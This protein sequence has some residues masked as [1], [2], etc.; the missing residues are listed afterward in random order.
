MSPLRSLHKR[1]LILGGYGTFGARIAEMLASEPGIQIIIAGRDRFKAELLANRLH[2]RFPDTPIEGLRL[3]H[4]SINLPAQ[5][6]DLNLQLLI[7]CAGPF[8]GQGYHIAAACIKNRINYIDIADAT[9]FVCGISAL[10]S[11]AE[12]AGIQVISGA[13]SLPAL[14]S[15]ALGTLTR[16]FSQV[17]DIDITIAPAHRISRGLATVRSG[18]ESL[19]REF[20][21]TRNGTRETTYTGDDFRAIN[22]AHPVG[23]R[24]VCNFDV[25]DLQLI[26]AHIAGVRNVRF[27]TGLQPRTLQVGL[28]LCAKLARIKLPGA[29]H[30][31]LP[32]LTRMGQQLAARWPGGSHHGGMAIEV[33]GSTDNAANVRARWQILGLNG[34]GPWIPA[35]PAAAMGKK[36]LRGESTQ[37]G[38]RPCWQLLQLEVILEELSPFAVVTTLEQP[39]SAA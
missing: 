2:H 20:S 39:Q 31:L 36:I 29:F 7:H 30:S 4:S 37:P 15:A 24:W 16:P 32:R 19:G 21:I 10:N 5:L 22:I 35:A 13:S 11:S 9:D 34:D 18:F 3:D 8:Q 28:T 23:K 38:A 14:S 25:P 1:V 33:S 27:G 6:H 12:Q 17:D 26:P